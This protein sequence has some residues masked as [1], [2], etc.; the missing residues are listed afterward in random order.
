MQS[1]ESPDF[2]RSITRRAALGFGVASGLAIAS[3]P[4]EDALGKPP[5]FLKDWD[6]SPELKAA[7]AFALKT[8]LR[9]G[10]GYWAVAYADDKFAGEPLLIG[11]QALLS[12]PQPQSGTMPTGWGIKSGSI[13]AGPSAVV[14]LIH[15]VNGQDVHVTLLPGESMANMSTM[16][17]ADG[18]SSWKLY[19]TVDLRPPY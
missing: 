2:A 14:R 10:P 15:K 12:K 16:A 17:I 11:K 8:D 6:W 13:V 7:S 18:I 9:C 19:P 5:S 4:T 1:N 3:L